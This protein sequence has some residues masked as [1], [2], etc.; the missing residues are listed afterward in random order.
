MKDMIRLSISLPV[1]LWGQIETYSTRV[2][3]VSFADAVRRLILAGL[4]AERRAEK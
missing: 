1:E 4:R 3:A 2:G